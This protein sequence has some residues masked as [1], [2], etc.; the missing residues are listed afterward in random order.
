MF[1]DCGQIRTLCVTQ[2]P[3][4]VEDVTGLQ[5]AHRAPSQAVLDTTSPN[6]STFLISST[7]MY[8]TYLEFHIQKKKK[9][10]PAWWLT[11]VIPALREAEAG[12]SRAQEIETILVNMVKLHLY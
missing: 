7:I 6:T 12:G 1:A 9:Y 8:L 2:I 3:A 5:K 4:T 10:R 11:P